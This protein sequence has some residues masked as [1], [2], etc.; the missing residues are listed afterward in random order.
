MGILISGFCLAKEMRGVAA[1]SLFKHL[2]PG[3]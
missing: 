3:S 2:D 1:A